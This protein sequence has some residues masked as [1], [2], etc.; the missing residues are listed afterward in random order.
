[1][2]IPSHTSQKMQPL[3]VSCFK[4]FKQYLQEDKAA[5]GLENPNWANGVM[6]RS[7]L[8]GMATNALK[9]ALKPSTILSGFKATGMCSILFLICIKCLQNHSELFY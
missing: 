9:K 3:D 8:A 1:M 4:P 6:L 5:M 2:S 7:T